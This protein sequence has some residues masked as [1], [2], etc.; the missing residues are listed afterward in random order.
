[1]IF[2]QL[3]D[4]ERK[5]C[6]GPIRNLF[7]FSTAQTEKHPWIKLVKTFDEFVISGEN[8][9][10]WEMMWFHCDS[11]A[12][13]LV[14][15]HAQCSPTGSLIK[16]TYRRLLKRDLKHWV[17]FNCILRGK[18][19]WLMLWNV[20]FSNFLR[21]RMLHLFFFRDSNLPKL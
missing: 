13:F 6:L 2:F 3:A 1:M 9:G 11:L 17:H 5:N 18:H 19:K 15:C 7:S 8:A 20:Y 12:F 21:L 14:L 16:T 4:W 10:P